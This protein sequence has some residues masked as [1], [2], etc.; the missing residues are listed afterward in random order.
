[1]DQPRFGSLP[2]WGFFRRIGWRLSDRRTW[3]SKHFGDKRSRQNIRDYRPQLHAQVLIPKKQ[4][5]HSN[6]TQ[7]VSSRLKAIEI[8]AKARSGGS[9]AV[10]S[11]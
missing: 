7:E 3:E 8:Y 9:K 4:L 11:R 2:G 5:R 6:A 10:A 1:M